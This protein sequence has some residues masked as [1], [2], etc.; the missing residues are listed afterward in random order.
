MGVQVDDLRR[1]YVQCRILAT[2][3]CINSK[4]IK[5]LQVHS[6]VS[7]GQKRFK[8]VSRE[9]LSLSLSEYQEHNKIS[10]NT[11]S[12]PAVSEAF[13]GTFSRRWAAK[14]GGYSLFDIH[15]H[16]SSHSNKNL[17][18]AGDQIQIHSNNEAL[19][20]LSQTSNYQGDRVASI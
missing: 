2:N 19:F 17:G 13:H 1:A 10:Q 9:C 15:Q 3:S 18:H 20:C 8:R 11:Q 12:L 5:L 7:K 6:K 14:T 4:K 16:Q